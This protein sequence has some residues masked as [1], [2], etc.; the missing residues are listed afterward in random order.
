[1]ISYQALCWDASLSRKW[2]R[3]EMVCMKV[4]L[5]KGQDHYL[6]GWK[7]DHILSKSLLPPSR[8]LRGGGMVSFNFLTLSHL[9]CHLLCCILHFLK[10]QEANLSVF[11]KIGGISICWCDVCHINTQKWYIIKWECKIYRHDYHIGF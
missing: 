3:M 5:Q 1:M 2:R 11:L 7:W 9:A 10:H 4:W 6:T 8:V